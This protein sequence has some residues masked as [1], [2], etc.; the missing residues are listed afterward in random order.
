[1]PR[2]DFNS[3]RDTF[4]TYIRVECGLAPNTIEAYARDLRDL[5]TDLESRG[6]ATISEIT[7]RHLAEHIASLR[8]ERAMS[9][10]SVARHL[11]TIKVLF[12]FLAAERRLEENPA[13]W[14]DQPTRWS[15]LPSVLSP[16]DVR[17]LV[18]A[19][20][21]PPGGWDGKILPLWLRDRAMLELMYACGLRASEVGR[22]KHT[23][24][25]TTL[26][27]VR[28]L[29]K[30]NR[31]RLVP[32]GRP[33]EAALD[34][35]LK[36]CRPRLVRPDGRDEGR[37]LLSRTGRPLERVAV[38]Q[39]VK[40]HAATAGVKDVHPHTL[41]HSFATH[42]LMGGADLRVVQELLGHADIATTQ[43]YTH[44]D[45]SRLKDVHRRFHPRA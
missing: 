2:D 39:I 14:L 26:G 36:E 28:V 24:I 41:R 10:S 32:M 6:L 18:E 35:Y 4:L 23:D 43:I 33:A 15:R 3:V 20:A 34:S 42:M 44:V 38:W 11:A 7:P 13:D 25:H 1:M 29:G 17:R 5:F 37:L 12:R 16:K 31:E 27:V 21:P 45:K 30:G 9:A 19:P 22:I 8:S 40:R